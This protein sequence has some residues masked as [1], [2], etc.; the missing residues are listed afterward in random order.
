MYCYILLTIFL[1]SLTITNS[2]KLKP[3]FCVN[4]KYY[5]LAPQYK[6]SSGKCTL[7]P[8]HNSDF[9][10]SGTENPASFTYCSIARTWEDMCG[11]NATRY[12]KKYKKNVNNTS[13]QE[14]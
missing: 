3:K 6:E 1:F 9:L 2:R 4:C 8:L 14:H 5:I 10:V 13:E 7:F 12:V 11:K